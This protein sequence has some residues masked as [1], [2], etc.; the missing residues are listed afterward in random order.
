M[1]EE[2]ETL[3]VVNKD[4]KVTDAIKRSEIR[5]LF[6]SDQGRY[7]RY[8]NCFLQ[9][10]E[11]KLWIPIRTATKKIAPNGLDFSASEHVQSGET[12]LQA[13]LRGLNE[14]L[15]ISADE[16]D[17]T[18]VGKVPPNEERRSFSSIYVVKQ[19]IAPNFNRDDFVSYEWLSVAGL[20][21]RLSSGVEAKYDLEPAV[22]LL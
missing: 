17:I 1:N 5:S 20:R 22:A 12:Y 10:S 19:D 3:D 6:G 11:G 4:D 8:A 7:V 16:A 15:N 9:N 13:I 18:F 21:Q 2:N 14:E